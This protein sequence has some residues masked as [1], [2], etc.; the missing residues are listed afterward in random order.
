MNRFQCPFTLVQLRPCSLCARWI[1]WVWEEEWDSSSQ[2][3]LPSVRLAVGLLG[4]RGH[5]VVEGSHRTCRLST[6]LRLDHLP[7]RFLEWGPSPAEATQDSTRCHRWT[8]S[9][10]VSVSMWNNDI[11]LLSFYFLIFLNFVCGLFSIFQFLGGNSL[12]LLRRKKAVF[13]N[14]YLPFPSVVLSH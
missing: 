9:S 5:L 6:P 8:H 13:V 10:R 12:S 7:E 4:P 1:R 14:G 2:H 11:F 3:P